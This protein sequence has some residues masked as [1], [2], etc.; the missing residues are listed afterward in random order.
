MAKIG[1]VEKCIESQFFWGV[2]TGE[3][4]LNGQVLQSS[5]WSKITLSIDLTYYPD[6]GVSTDVLYCDCT[7]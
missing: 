7:I 4:V 1:P 6:N 2:I 5:R 3:M